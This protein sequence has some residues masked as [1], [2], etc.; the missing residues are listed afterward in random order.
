MVIV[1][2]TL[3]IRHPFTDTH[4][5][6]RTG[7]LDNN[8]QNTLNTSN[9]I[10]MQITP[11]G[12]EAN[13]LTRAMTLRVLIKPETENWCRKIHNV[14]STYTR[15]QYTEHHLLVFILYT[16][17]RSRAQIVRKGATTIIFRRFE[18]VKWMEKKVRKATFF[19][20][21]TTTYA[22]S[23]SL[24]FFCTWWSRS[25]IVVLWSHCLWYIPCFIS[26]VTILHNICHTQIHTAEPKTQ[27]LAKNR[28]MQLQKSEIANW[29][30]KW[31]PISFEQ[32]EKS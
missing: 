29:W 5:R 31:K 16:L 15:T 12:T 17:F 27:C 2:H 19:Y 23:L 20:T 10:H 18:P 25:F 7:E 11:N 24:C 1:C 6:F 4:S 22:F 8:T 3:Y 28:E 21:P 14:H 32:S 13:K 26:S 9:S 30:R